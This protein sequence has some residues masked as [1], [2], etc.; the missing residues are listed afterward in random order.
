M[1]DGGSLFS[2]LSLLKHSPFLSLRVLQTSVE[3]STQI[4]PRGLIHYIPYFNYY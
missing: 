2:K 4:G 3:T 1:P